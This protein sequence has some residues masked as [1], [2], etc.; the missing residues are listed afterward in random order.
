MAI[1]LRDFQPSDL[2]PFFEMDQVCFAPEIAYSLKKFR[3]ILRSRDSVG[4]VAEDSSGRMAG[5]ILA[6]GRNRSGRRY[7]HVITI[8]VAPEMRRQGVGR[9]LIEALERRVAAQGMTRLLLEVAER[10]VSAYAF[11]SRLG[12]VET[13]LRMMNYYPDGD[14]AIEMEKIFG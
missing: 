11:Y 14:G 9:M 2:E 8:D 4:F 7:S 6:D 5:F 1:S 12:F 3:S 13:G 10:N